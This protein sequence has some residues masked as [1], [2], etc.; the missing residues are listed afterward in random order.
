MPWFHNKISVPKCLCT[1]KPAPNL[2]AKS[3]GSICKTIANKYKLQIS[4]K[5]KFLYQLFLIFLFFFPFSD[6]LKFNSSYCKFFR[7]RFV[8]SPNL[9]MPIMVALKRCVVMQ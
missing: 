3:L 7:R 9:S 2:F 6:F 4:E 1:I 5:K 8:L